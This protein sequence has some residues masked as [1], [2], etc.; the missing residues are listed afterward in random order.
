MNVGELIDILRDLDPET[1]VEMA[2]IAPVDDMSDDITVD[3]YPVEGVL[4]RDPRDHDGNPMVWLI[5]GE[6]DDVDEFID[7]IESQTEQVHTAHQGD[8]LDFQ[9]ASG[10]RHSLDR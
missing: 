1:A 8:L 10:R 2:I 5:G 3:Q 6:A 4:P 7:A 9:A